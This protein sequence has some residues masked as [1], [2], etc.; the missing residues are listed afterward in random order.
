MLFCINNYLFFYTDH[1]SLGNVAL[2]LDKFARIASIISVVNN[3]AEFILA[4]VSRL[5]S[6]R[7]RY[8]LSVTALIV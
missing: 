3:I 1:Q 8:S 5:S 4:T 7:L 6:S 2:D